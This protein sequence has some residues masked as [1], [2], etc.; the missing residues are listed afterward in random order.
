MTLSV[1]LN[2]IA[3]A[4]TGSCIFLMQASKRI[5]AFLL[6]DQS[7]L[8][9]EYLH[10]YNLHQPPPSLGCSPLVLTGLGL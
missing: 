6:V 9:G 5:G 4:G 8:Q 2:E 7:H 1:G 10:D 3:M